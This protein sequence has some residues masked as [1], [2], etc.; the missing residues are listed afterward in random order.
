MIFGTQWDRNTLSFGW[1]SVSKR[2]GGPIEISEDTVQLRVLIDH[3]A[4]E[5]FTGAGETLTTRCIF[6]LPPKTMRQA[7]HL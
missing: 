6:R 3:S 7:L 4:V 5:I 2:I 1:D